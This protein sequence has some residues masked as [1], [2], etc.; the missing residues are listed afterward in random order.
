MN[1][2]FFL[3][4][5]FAF[6]IFA[7]AEAKSGERWIVVTSI[8]YPTKA[9]QQLAEMPGWELVVVADKKTPKDWQ[10]DNCH[11][12]SV[13]KQRQLGY[14]IIDI[15]PW[16]HY[17]R[18]NIGYLYAISQGATVIYET[19]DDN[20]IDNIPSPEELQEYCEIHCDE[21]STANIYAYFG[22]PTLW[23][24]GFPL[25]NIH[26]SG[27]FWVTNQKEPLKIGV[28]Q[29]L[30][31]KDPD[32]DAIYRLTQGKEVY[33]A[34]KPPCSLPKGLFC[35]YNT[36]NTTFAYDAFWSLY[37][38]V[39][40]AFRVCDIWRGYIGQRLLW[41]I[42]H[43]VCF[44]SATAIQERNAHNYFMDFCDELQLYLQAGELVR[45]LK[46]WDTN[47]T[48]IAERYRRLVEALIEK[49][50]LPSNEIKFLQA[51]L[52]DL[53]RVGYRFPKSVE[54]Y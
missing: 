32:V 46:K 22:Q 4:I 18:K 48:E 3:R 12:L 9:L 8:F 23:P 28:I 1:R 45:F 54:T 29:G 34:K 31:N 53:T 2:R 25:E 36:Q 26:A 14:E 20:L 7:M 38:P 51:W 13:E 19:D 49:K 10:L 17:C 42:Q 41:D 24:R 5:F 33:F 21:S 40:T 27:S 30:V 11:F 47:E 15:L 52:R 39:T 6:A 44:T 50:F 16:N 35:P 37:I 43:T